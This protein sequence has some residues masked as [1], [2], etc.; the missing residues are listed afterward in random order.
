MI[1]GWRFRII[2][3]ALAANLAS[4]LYIYQEVD[5]P[6]LVVLKAVKDY[7]LQLPWSCA[8]NPLSVP[9]PAMMLEKNNEESKVVAAREFSKIKLKAPR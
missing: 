6:K 1:H 8:F 7:Y 9:E 5:L 3:K 4:S 2:S